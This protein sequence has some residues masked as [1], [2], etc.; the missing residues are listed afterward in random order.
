MTNTPPAHRGRPRRTTPDLRTKI[1]RRADAKVARQAKAITA[2]AMFPQ[3]PDEARVRQ[4]LIEAAFGWSNTTVWRR[5]KSKE[6][7]APRLDG[8][9]AS[10][11]AGEVRAALAGKVAC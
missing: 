7:P 1:Q 6:F 3:M 9:I 2:L 5:V 10:W 8:R 4:P 11:S